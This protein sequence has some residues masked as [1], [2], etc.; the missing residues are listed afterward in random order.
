[1]GEATHIDSTPMKNKTR[2]IEIFIWDN[3]ENLK[4][5]FYGIL[6]K[7]KKLVY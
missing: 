3:S 2:V 1:M 4:M 5:I 6:I 7:N